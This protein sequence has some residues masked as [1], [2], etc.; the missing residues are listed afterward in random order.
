MTG[1]LTLLPAHA[2]E[3]RPKLVLCV[4]VDQ[5]RTDYVELL[6]PLMGEG[7]F[8]RLM[9]H[10]LYFRDVEA[11]VARL[12]RASGTAL[13]MTGTTPGTSGVHHATVWD[14]AAAKRSDIL[15]DET[16]M[17]YYTQS[18]YSPAALK[19]GTVVDEVM[20]D[21]AGLSLAWSVG[22]DPQMAVLMAGHAGTGAVWLDPSSGKWSSSTYYK[23]LPEPVLRRNAGRGLAAKLDTMQWKPLLPL[24]K[25]PGL[26]AQ[27]R[28]YDF[29]HTFPGKERDVYTKFAL[30]PKGNTEVTDIAVDLLKTLRLG[31]RGD[32]VDVLCVGLVAAPFPYVKD[33]DYRLELEDT[34]LRL[35][36]DLAR[37]VSAA[38]KATGGDFVLSLVST[39]YY[40]DARPDDPKYRMP[41]GEFSVKKAISLLNAFYT[42]RFGP[43]HYVEAIIDGCV[44]LNHDTLATKGVSEDEAASQGKVFLSKM[45]GVEGVYTL[46]DLLS[47]DTERE[48][49]LRPAVDPKGGVDLWMEFAPGWN[50]TDDTLY[51]A[52]TAPVRRSRYAAPAFFLGKGVPAAR[53]SQEVDMRML[54]PTL[55]S[56]LH[57]RTPN[58]ADLKGYLP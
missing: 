52:V 4:V 6:T 12:D 32:A 14:H 25:Y 10:G 48:R 1:I 39:G 40:D 58:S 27:K 54:A 17:G 7:G 5:L 43:G 28:M 37:L 42:S 16:V 18:R 31:S 30:S 51:P 19:A 26:P 8:R 49:A 46:T 24:D 21:G 2:A 9:G 23:E 56:I 55:S 53:V 34:Y 15:W 45:S 3:G 36:K 38:D 20:I 57:M 29:R 50:V 35:D 41:S 47:G 13:A 44:Y 33:G 11:G 22:T